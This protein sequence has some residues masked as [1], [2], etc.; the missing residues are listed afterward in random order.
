MSVDTKC[1]ELLSGAGL[2]PVLVGGRGQASG[3]IMR[4]MAE[5]KKKHSGQYKNPSDNNYNSTMNHFVPFDYKKLAN[6]DQSGRNRSDYGASPF[7]IKHFGSPE[8]V[9]YVPKAQRTPAQSK[10]QEVPEETEEQKAA[11]LQ[12]KAEELA[13]KAKELLEATQKKE[14]VKGFLKGRIAI[15]KAKEILSSKKEVAAKKKRQ[16]DEVRE[17]KEKKVREE[18]DRQ[19]AA[20]RARA[21][22]DAIDEENRKRSRE[23]EE[24][25]SKKDSELLVPILEDALKTNKVIVLAND[26]R[27]GKK[28]TKLGEHRTKAEI[29]FDKTGYYG[30]L[31]YNAK[32]NYPLEYITYSFSEYR[33]ELADLKKK[34]LALKSAG[35]ESKSGYKGKLKHDDDLKLYGRDSA[36]EAAGRDL[37]H[38]GYE[39]GIQIE[40]VA[41]FN[42]RAPN[43][44]FG[45]EPSDKEYYR[46]LLAKMYDKEDVPRMERALKTIDEAI[47]SS[48]DTAL[49]QRTEA[50]LATAKKKAGIKEEPKEEPKPK[51][52]FKVKVMPR[53]T[54][55]EP[56]EEPK[57][58]KTF[59]VKVKP[60]EQRVY[61]YQKEHP[62]LSNA[63]I[64]KVF[65]IGRETVRQ[66]KLKWAKHLAA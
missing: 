16:E 57:P 53:E 21:A 35:E 40:P 41:G 37:E 65:D 43:K 36:W 46:G 55:E 47:A 24:D 19:D 32:R 49:K 1:Y 15:K 22:L 23:F 5:N 27:E 52:T 61:E 48:S 62:L 38:W 59:K 50:Q 51:K 63:A 18:K 60:R 28:A 54:T 17:A 12:A 10:I 26:V 3:F 14:K 56:K 64:G 6:S 30:N 66:D 44:P 58:K 4:M 20:I 2:E 25:L 11:R 39:L 31:S 13:A 7:I 33:K 45:T 34:T 9:P 29:R 42:V 8:S